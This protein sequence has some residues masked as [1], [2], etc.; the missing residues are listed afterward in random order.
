MITRE[1]RLAMDSSALAEARLADIM[2]LADVKRLADL[3]AEEDAMWP[4]T[5]ATRPRME[6]WLRRT[7]PLLARAGTHRANLAAMRQRGVRGKRGDWDFASTETQWEYDTLEELVK[8]LETFQRETVPDVQDRLRIAR[9]VK[10]LTIDERATEWD[11]AIA[12]VAGSSRYRSLALMPILGLVPLGPDPD[13]GLEEF[14]HFGSG[15]VP[16]RD[17]DGRLRLREDMSVVLVLIPGGAFDMGA[18]RPASGHRAGSPNVDP[19]AR[20][21]DGPVH[22]VTLH[23][24]LI[25][26]YELTQ[27]QWQAIGED[28][29]SAYQPGSVH[30]GRM[31]TR[32]HPVEQVRWATVSTALSR[33]ELELPTEAQ[34]EYATRAGSTTVYWAGNEARSMDGAMNIADRYCAEHGGPGSWRFEMWLDDGHVVHAPVGTYRGNGFGLHDTAGNVWEWC[35]DRYGSY[36]SEVRDGTGA[37]VAGEGA[38]RLFRGGGFRSSV[39]H[40]RSADR[41][42]LY[43]AGFRAYDVGVRVARNLGR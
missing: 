34:W 12:R 18:H 11:A 31:T 6:D 22:R 43:G 37:R 27:G 33:V 2:R 42:T 4:A 16:E 41:Y 9:T 25:G 23:P 17:A 20:A 26:K 19:Q 28:N 40:A 15:E 13:S 21:I 35:A 39:V 36:E 10:L 32:L 29:T 30:G 7:E 38:P 14:A 5:P 3:D 8:R 1:K 24:F